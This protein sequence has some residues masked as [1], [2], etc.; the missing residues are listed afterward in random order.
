M[1]STLIVGK[2]IFSVVG[3]VAFVSVYERFIVTIIRSVL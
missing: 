1:A 3:A 2:F